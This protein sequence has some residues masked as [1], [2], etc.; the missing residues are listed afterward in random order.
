V[1]TNIGYVLYKRAQ[2][3][4][5]KEALVVDDVRRTWS[6]LNERSNRAASAMQK[7]GVQKGDRV[8]ILAMNEPEY[9]ELF[10]ALGKIGVVMTPVNYRLAGPEI[11]YIVN[12]CEASVLIFGPEY[13]EVVDGIRGAIPAKHL[14]AFGDKT[15]D[16]AVK[17][18]ELIQAASPEEPELTGGDLDTH[19]I[20]YTSGTTGRPK[21]AELTHQGYYSN[22]V[23]L[24]VTLPD[25]GYTMLMP[26]PLFHIG[27]LAPLIFCVHFGHK[28]I[29]QRT[30]EPAGFLGAIKNEGVTWF[31]S[32]PQ[33]L[34]FLRSVPEFE[35]YDWSQIKM[36]LVYAAPVPVTLLKEFAEK[37][38]GVQ[39]LYG[40]TECTGPATVIDAENAIEKA[41]S[42]GLPFFHTDIR[43]VDDNDNDLPPGEIGE[44]LI[45]C[46]HPMSGYYK[47]PEATASTIK[48]GWIYSGDLAQ[49]DEDGFLYIMDRKKDMI[50]SG[51]ENIYP[52]EVEDYLLGHPQVADVGVI[53]C[54]DEK[55]GESVKAVV[56]LNKGEEMSEEDLI[57]WAKTKMGKFKVPRQVVF[58]EEIP[59]TPTGK[60]LKRVLRDQYN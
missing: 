13:A 20:L 4:P 23:N 12:N 24:G 56:V 50:I 31:G 18:E 35:T 34:L 22:S 11:E 42:C 49:K 26:L 30:F 55:W 16:W 58:T 45:R 60:I 2:L 48:D 7:L 25:I 19:T 33:V 40:M 14:V 27:A 37:G 10:F 57:E 9:V 36:A 41:G 43:V 6:E 39:Q 59:R 51:G 29:F 38:M 15:P 21:G 28:M 52:A 5:D 54:A 47:N 53:G 44:V 32:V 3:N 1:K 8:A 17:Y 46:T